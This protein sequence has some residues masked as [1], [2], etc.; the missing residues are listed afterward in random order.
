MDYFVGFNFN[1]NF[2]FV[3]VGYFLKGYR[4]FLFVIVVRIVRILY[5][6]LILVNKYRNCDKFEVNI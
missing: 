3:L 5:I 2:N 4:Y 6:L 1:F